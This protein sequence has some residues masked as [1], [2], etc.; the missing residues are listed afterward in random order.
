MFKKIFELGFVGIFLTLDTIVYDLVGKAFNIFIAIAGARLLSTEA[1]MAV[2]NKIYMI[3]GILMLFVLA[4]S[5]LKSIVDPDHLKDELGAKLVKKIIIAVVGLGIT[6]VIFNVLYQAQGLILDN[7]ILGNLFFNDELLQNGDDP[8][9]YISNIGGYVTATSMWQA[10]FYPSEESGAKASDIVSDPTKYLI[11]TVG[12]GAA[13]AVGA[14][15][16]AALWEIPVVNIFVIGATVFACAKSYINSESYSESTSA[17][18]GEKISLDEA[19]SRTA[20]GDSFKIYLAFM[21]NYLDD[22]EITYLYIISTIAGGFAL[23]AFISFSI[24]MGIRAAKLAYYQI[25]A[26]IPLIYQIVPKG[27]SVFDDYKKGVISTF[28]EVFIRISVVYV[29]VYI[30]CHITELFSSA[31]ALWGNQELNGPSKYLALA[32]LILGLIAFCRTAPQFIADSLKLPTG[33]MKLGLREKLAN[34]GA[35]AA[36]GI[37][38]A[39]I[40]SGFRGFTKRDVA[41]RG[42]GERA[43]R[44]IGYGV[45]GLFGGAA[46]AGWN[47]F[48]PGKDRNEAKDWSSMRD[49]ATRASRAQ[50]D[51]TDARNT[52]NGNRD[53]ATKELQGKR[54]EYAAQ[55][56]IYED[57]SKTQAE[58]DAARDKMVALREEMAKLEN[59]I[60]ENTTAGNWI[61]DRGKRIRVWAAGSFDLSLEDAAIKMGGAAGDLQDKLR[62]TIT[63]KGSDELKAAKKEW[64]RLEAETISEYKGGYTEESYNEELRRRLSTGDVATKKA[65]LDTAIASGNAAAIATAR[66]EYDT[67]RQAAIDGL[68]AEAK[69]TGDELTRE[70]I[71]LQHRRSDAKKIYEAMA[72]AEI[73]AKL[74]AGDSDYTSVVA[75]FLRDHADLIQN[76]PNMVVPLGGGE[77]ITVGELIQAGFGADALTGSVS[78][79]AFSGPT[80]LKVQD[81]GKNEVS[82]YEYRYDPTTKTGSYYEMV[83]SSPGVGDWHASGTVVQPGDIST[84]LNALM[85]AHPGGS[86]DFGTGVNKVKDQG[87]KVKNTMPT[88]EGY[89]AKKNLERQKNEGRK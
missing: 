4:Y 33:N 2:A 44:R 52:R 31:T 13:C 7:N 6:P 80:V 21:D 1:Y 81:A 12:W 35:F 45:S 50:D 56:A 54:G 28:I 20:G 10:F 42:A 86:I 89:V 72:D 36:G 25:I 43:L 40:T 49:V 26:P 75:A 64:D 23:Y 48:G 17:N 41:G 66:S 55:Q 62:S 88:S 65:A 39:G 82:R 8:N 84:R 77:T 19:Y 70:S 29:V 73:Q 22:G 37:V 34:G 61:T 18:N 27:E 60:F 51:A 9:E 58:R 30:I 38:G 53:R 57:A 68:N 14:A 63:A 46:R 83:E 87:K 79:A 5:I 16:S 47:Q 24:D 74:A 76:H 78:A 32:L 85:S 59:E 71:E 15:A 67:A 69:K 11:S 3:V